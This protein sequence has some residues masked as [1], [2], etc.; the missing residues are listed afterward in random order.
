MAPRRMPSSMPDKS[1][2][3]AERSRP[4]R[5]RIGMTRSLHIIVDSAIVSTITMAVA[6]DRPPTNAKSASASWPWFSGSASTN[7]SASTRPCGNSSRPPKAIGSTNR[8]MATRYSGKIQTALR[9]CRSSTF[10]TTAI[11]NCRGRNMMANMD[12][13]VSDA[14]P[15]YS[16]PTAD[17]VVSRAS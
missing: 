1:R 4:R 15:A 13:S 17:S 7:V 3:P 11:W 12:S 9:R 2:V 6:A 14:Q 8:L 5:S 10:S 16:P